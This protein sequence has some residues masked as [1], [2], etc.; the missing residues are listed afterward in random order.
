MTTTKQDAQQRAIIDEAAELVLGR[1]GSH[2]LDALATAGANPRIRR[3]SKATTYG[4]RGGM[5]P[6]TG[7]KA[8]RFRITL[9]SGEVLTK[10]AFSTGAPICATAYRYQTTGEV[11]CAVWFEG[12]AVAW[13][14][15]FGRLPVVEVVA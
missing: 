1:D 2:M 3:R 13:E 15:D 9:P 11:G 10:R 4:Q 6:N 8:R 14:G 7:K 5:G 12:E